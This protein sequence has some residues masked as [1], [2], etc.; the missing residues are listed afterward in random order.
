MSMWGDVMTVLITLALPADETRVPI[1]GAASHWRDHLKET[2]AG[3]N[4]RKALFLR[5]RQ[6]SRRFERQRKGEVPPLAPGFY[7]SA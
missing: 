1:E 7:D 3:A 4:I 5:R 2:T 6:A